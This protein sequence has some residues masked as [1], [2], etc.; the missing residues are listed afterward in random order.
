[1]PRRAAG[2]RG[3]ALVLVLWVLVLLALMSAAFL[4]TTRSEVTLV[5][6]RIDAAQAEAV[7]DAG[8]HWAAARILAATFGDAADGATPFDGRAEEIAIAGGTAEVRIQDVGGLVDLNGADADLLAG[9]LAVAGAGP[10]DARMLADRIIDFRDPDERPGPDGAEDADYAAAGL[11]HDAKDG[12]F[13]RIDE[14]RQIP[15]MPPALASRLLPLVTV[16]S[17]SHGIDPRVAPPRVL[18]ALPGLGSAA[19]RILDARGRHGSDSFDPAEN[20]YFVASSRNVFRVTVLGETEAGGRFL[21]EAVI[22]I[23]GTDQGFEILDWV[24]R[25]ATPPP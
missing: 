22:R 20:P 16:H 5:R 6:A 7:A 18:A 3:I 13:T 10:E 9:L 15:D 24:Q 19:S 23:G 21:R 25:D 8:V 11:A 1:M 12:A 4:A 2:E 17:A 14:I